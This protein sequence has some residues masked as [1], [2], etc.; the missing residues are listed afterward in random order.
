MVKTCKI[1]FHDR[2][3]EIEKTYQDGTS[4]RTV[5]KTFGVS[6]DG[7]YR[8]RR[9]YILSLEEIQAAEVIQHIDEIDELLKTLNFATIAVKRLLSLP[10]TAETLSGAFRALRV[11]TRILEDLLKA[12]GVLEPPRG[13]EIHIDRE[14]TILANLIMDLP[15]KWRTL[16]VDNLKREAERE[17]AAADASSGRDQTGSSSISEASVP[18]D[19]LGKLAS[20]TDG[21]Q[22]S[23]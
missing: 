4:W 2:R 7:Y 10:I 13:I 22:Y 8:H 15:E 20:E 21:R 12:R 3:A 19:G 18:S 1:C 9:H 6:K 17:Q 5:V 23:K 11:R 16:I 14:Y